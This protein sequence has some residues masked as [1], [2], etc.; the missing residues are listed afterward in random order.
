MSANHTPGQLAFIESPYEANRFTIKIGKD[1]LMAVQHNGHQHTP[2]Q[3]EN[4]RRTV[5]CWNACEGIDTDELERIAA[6]GGMLGPREDVARIAAQRDAL[7]AALQTFVNKYDAA[8][9]GELGVGLVNGDFDAA[10]A[11]IKSATGE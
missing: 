6:T 1:W 5:A 3:R 10:R 8:P 2:E 11:A 4:M 9:D 7:L